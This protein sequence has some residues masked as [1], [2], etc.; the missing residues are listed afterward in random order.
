MD[1]II[2]DCHGCYYSLL[3]LLNKVQSKD[4][5]AKFIFLGDYVD[6]GRHS[7]EVIDLLI[8]LQREQHVCLRG[9][10]DDVVD[11]IL[12]KHSIS[13]LIELTSSL[14]EEHVVLWWL[15]NG[16]G[17][18]LKSYRVPY[19]HLD[20][21]DVAMVFRQVVSNEHKQFFRELP[22]YWSNDTHFVCHASYPIDREVPREAKFFK[23]ELNNDT[24]WTRFGKLVTSVTTKWDKIGVFGHTP[25]WCYISNQNN[26]VPVVQDKIR[27]IDLGCFTG[28]CLAAYCCQEDR[29]I[30]VKS[31]FRDV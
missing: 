24:L 23:N 5:S 31:D 25:T 17:A 12:N 21:K 30:I 20:I 10:H 28:G 15:R 2:G 22:L 14:A 13:D 19:E 16:F 7:K 11:W 8:Q 29:F 26:P 18:T 9:N 3:D 6:R 4:S 1:W 27:I